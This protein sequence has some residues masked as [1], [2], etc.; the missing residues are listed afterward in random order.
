MIALIWIAG[1]ALSSPMAYAQRVIYVSDDWPFCQNVNL[2]LNVMLGYRAVLV[3]V[4]YVIPLS[5]MTWAY[6]GIGFAL[7]GSSVPGNAQSQR[8]LNLMRNKKR[9]RKYIEGLFFFF[10]YSNKM[11][12]KYSKR[13]N[14]DMIISN[15]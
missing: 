12:I 2:S 9:V 13:Y 8:D 14:F 6:S 4:Q 7:W 5:I 3:I 1:L 10:K 11:N 15:Y